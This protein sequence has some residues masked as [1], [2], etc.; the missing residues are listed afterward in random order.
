MESMIEADVAEMTPC[1]NELCKCKQLEASQR[2]KTSHD[3]WKTIKHI[4]IMVDDG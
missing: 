2:S 3:N 4:T 1:G